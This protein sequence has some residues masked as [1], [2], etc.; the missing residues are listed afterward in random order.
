LAVNA[1]S[2][3]AGLRPWRIAGLYALLRD[4]GDCGR[5]DDAAADDPARDA[6]IAGT[7]HP[8]FVAGPFS[9]VRADR[10][11]DPYADGEPNF[12]GAYDAVPEASSSPDTVLPRGHNAASR[13]PV[14][15]VGVT[16]PAR[17]GEDGRPTLPASADTPLPTPAQFTAPWRALLEKTPP[18]PLVWTYEELGRDLQGNASPERSRFL[19][20]LLAALSLPRGSSAFWPLDLPEPADAGDERRPGD[21]GSK[22]GVGV[23]REFAAGVKLLGGGVVVYFGAD[24]VLRSGFALTVRTPFTQ[25]IAGGL[26][27]IL[28]PALSEPAQGPEQAEKAA[29]YLRSV[30]TDHP[31]LRA[32]SGRG[33]AG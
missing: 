30:L 10:L 28:L 8:A 23:S 9:R 1:L 22:P 2:L 19:K 21:D 27:H 6:F 29:T 20:T 4:D 11:A 16:A 33:G 5:S 12:S 17:T 24:A 13:A 32:R 3:A 31:L 7:E 26:L 15:A 14:S 25:Q 18:A